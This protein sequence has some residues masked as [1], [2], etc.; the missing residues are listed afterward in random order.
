MQINL[1]SFL[2][3]L[4]DGSLMCPDSSVLGAT[5]A[6]SDDYGRVR[7]A[8][9]HAHAHIKDLNS[10]MAAAK[11]SHRVSAMNLCTR[12]QESIQ[13][14]HTRHSQD[15]RDQ[16]TAHTAAL[17]AQQVHHKNDLESHRQRA[18]AALTSAQV[19]NKAQAAKITQLNGQLA[20]LQ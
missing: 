4:G 7:E 16:N 1:S 10:Q 5:V 8:L 18:E 3:G 9:F 2:T 19:T 14:Q 20:T 17:T 6:R 15:V 12:H 13:R 11:A